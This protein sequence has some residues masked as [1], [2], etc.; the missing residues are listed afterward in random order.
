MECAK[1]CGLWRPGPDAII[2][3][4]IALFLQFERARDSRRAPGG[5]GFER[6]EV[7][8]STPQC[9]GWTR[10]ALRRGRTRSRCG[11]H[12]RDFSEKPS[13][14]F[15]AVRRLAFRPPP[16]PRDAKLT[17]PALASLLL[18]GP[19][20]WDG[21]PDRRAPHRHGEEPGADERGDVRDGRRLV[22]RSKR[23]TARAVPRHRRADGRVRRHQRRRV[24]DEHDGVAVPARGRRRG[25]RR[26]QPPAPAPAPAEDGEETRSRRRRRWCRTRGSR[27]LSPAAPRG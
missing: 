26:R 7:P 16:P 15:A 14:T 27:A 12:P 19:N 25:R 20:S 3:G 18:A 24:L 17:S 1:K 4:A 10:R 5:G 11:S 8:A 2:F 6:E 9:P 21:R 13:Q 22:A 23:R